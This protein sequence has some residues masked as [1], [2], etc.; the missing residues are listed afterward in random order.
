MTTDV[1]SCFCG[2]GKP[3]PR[4]SKSFPLCTSANARAWAVCRSLYGD[5]GV[6]EQ[7]RI[8]AR[9]WVDERTVAA[10]LAGD[11]DEVRRRIDFR[12]AHGLY[13]DPDR[14]VA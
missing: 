10:A 1:R 12:A 6:A 9:F 7:S 8:N 13:A 5:A 4:R 3:F 11:L 14:A 2:C